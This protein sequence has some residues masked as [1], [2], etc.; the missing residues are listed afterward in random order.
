[1]SLK[2]GTPRF[3]SQ[4]I[5]KQIRQIQQQGIA[6]RGP[7]GTPGHNRIQSLIKH[8]VEERNNGVIALNHLPEALLQS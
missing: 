2:T 1:M 3:F 7:V 6:Q 4:L 5:I 8:L